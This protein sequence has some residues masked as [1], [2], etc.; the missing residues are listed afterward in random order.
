M[1]D[2]VTLE[3]LKDY[4]GRELSPSDWVVITQERIDNF[5]DC[6]DDH[7]FIHVDPERMK[8]S[9]FGCTIAHGF[10]SLSLLSGHGSAD[11]PELE[12][13][14]LSLNYGLD[15]VRFLQPVKVNSR[16]RFHTR[17]VSVSER[18][19][20]RVLIKSEKTMEIEGLGRDKPAM[21]AEALAM[22]VTE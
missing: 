15:R 12:N 14:I 19:P 8:D 9:P 17:I 1:P 13:R 20:G 2:T 16:V 7:Q 6:T 18:S 22:A 4:E 11:W 21:V 10:L 3:E 5:A